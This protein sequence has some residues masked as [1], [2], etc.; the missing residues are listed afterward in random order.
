MMRLV[1]QES[2]R[3]T[4]APCRGLEV[5]AVV[6]TDELGTFTLLAGRA[7]VGPHLVSDHVT[8]ITMVTSR[9][10]REQSHLA[11]RIGLTPEAIAKIEEV[12]AGLTRHA[13]LRIDLAM[14][15]AYQRG[16]A[17]TTNSY[18]LI[19]TGM[20]SSS[21]Q[22]LQLSIHQSEWLQ[23]LEQ[24]EK[25]GCTVFEVPDLPLGKYPG[26]EQGRRILTEAHGR[27]VHGDYKGCITSAIGALES[28]AKHADGGGGDVKVG[29]DLLT[30]GAF[31]A[32]DPRAKLLDQQIKAL[33]DYGNKAGRHE[34]NPA[35]H[36]SR[37]EAE[38][39]YASATALMS[40]I[41]R[42]IHNRG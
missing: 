18:E 27:L 25:A 30:A 37:E 6:T 20:P 2:I 7:T 23:T 34:Q 35:L 19:P 13:A 11:L 40:F 1:K 41:S 9:T 17:S 26:A 15:F 4:P 36:N 12:R 5:G 10:D 39:V 8:C 38:F 21:H 16:A 32:A 33:K 3:G 31:E 28:A 29:F 14:T 42:S 22:S 24:I